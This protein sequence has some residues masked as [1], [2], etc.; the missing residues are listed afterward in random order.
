MV[1]SLRLIAAGLGTVGQVVAV[2]A[3]ANLGGTLLLGVERRA[4]E[5]ATPAA[6]CE[7]V[8]CGRA[9]VSGSGLGAALG[10]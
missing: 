4:A 5:I 2:V 10:V 1:R 7:A 9:G 3:V 8:Q 6:T